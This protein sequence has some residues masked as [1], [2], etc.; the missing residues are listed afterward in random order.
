MLNH[1]WSNKNQIVWK[2]IDYRFCT[3][4]IFMATVNN[5]IDISHIKKNLSSSLA[6]TT[7]PLAFFNKIGRKK[8]ELL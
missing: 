1:V 2:S 7:H 6:C 5:K 4:A 8:L 3:S